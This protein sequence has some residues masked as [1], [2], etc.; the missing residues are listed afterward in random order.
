MASPTID[1][2]ILGDFALHHGFT[3]GQAVSWNEGIALVEHLD[4]QRRVDLGDRESFQGQHPQFGMLV[5]MLSTISQ[6][7]VLS[8]RDLTARL[9]PSLSLV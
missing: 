1:S 3:H 4:V 2:N 5:V 6:S 9:R 7:Y 8:H